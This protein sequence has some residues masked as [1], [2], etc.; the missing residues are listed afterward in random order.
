MNAR[1]APDSIAPV[2][3]KWR[4]PALMLALPLLLAGVGGWVWLHGGESVSTDNAYVQQDKV[5]ISS[6]VTGRVV[7]VGQTESAMVKRG[8]VLFRIAQRPFE[9]ALAQA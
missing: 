9:I 8:D 4:R 6:D 3:S 7:A 5:S 2:R 1:I